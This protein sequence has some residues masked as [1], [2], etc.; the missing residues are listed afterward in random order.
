M[1]EMSRR[2]RFNDCPPPVQ[3]AG[4]AIY[5]NEY[6][7]KMFFPEKN[8]FNQ[9]S[10]YINEN[11]T[12][13]SAILN[14]WVI[15]HCSFLNTLTTKYV[16]IACPFSYH[17]MEIWYSQKGHQKTQWGNNYLINEH[18]W[19]SSNSHTTTQDKIIKI[20]DGIYFINFQW[21]WMEEHNVF[22]GF[23]IEDPSEEK[24]TNFCNK[25][26]KE[27]SEAEIKLRQSLEQPDAF[28]RVILP[29]NKLKEMTADV[30][31]FFTSK[32]LYEELNIAWKRGYL[33]TGP[34]GNGKTLWIRCLSKR[35]GLEMLK[36]KDMID[37]HGN[38]NIDRDDRSTWDQILYPS[39]YP[40]LYVLEDIDKFTTYQGGSGEH[41][42]AGI[43]SLHEL[44]QAIDGIDNPEGFI[45]VAT[46]NYPNTISEA[47]TNRPG[48]FDRI[49]QFEKP[50]PDLIKKLIHHHKIEL[51][52]DEG[53]VVNALKGFSMAFVEEMIKAAKSTFRKNNFTYDELSEILIRINQHNEMYKKH[54]ENKGAVGF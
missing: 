28:D 32:S 54:F 6:K 8:N 7:V 46:T 52:G 14:N 40:K 15:S 16:T 36:I 42:D 31:S 18:Y 50:S 12:S 9:D 13:L 1:N 26:S 3:A 30:E 22:Q 20:D 19:F 25:F 34:P 4:M 27:L 2:S 43:I 24:I 49:W 17:R 35:Y 5:N 45:L 39:N 33:L 29:E 44:L 10:A 48:R 41:A 23:L 51:N 37:N 21:F 11:Q 38:L 53:K 47:I